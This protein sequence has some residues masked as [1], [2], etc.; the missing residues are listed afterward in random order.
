MSCRKVFEMVLYIYSIPQL[1]YFVKGKKRATDSGGNPWLFAYREVYPTA[2]RKK[3]R[4]KYPAT[5]S[6]SHMKSFVN[7]FVANSVANHA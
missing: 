1:Q 3:R 5:C 6:I 4:R 7:R 2:E